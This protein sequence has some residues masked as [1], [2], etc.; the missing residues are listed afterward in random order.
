MEL[1][2]L[3][4][5]CYYLELRTLVGSSYYLMLVRLPCSCY[6]LELRT[7]ACS[8]YYLELAV[9]IWS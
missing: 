8:S 7:L 9:I 4:C 6:Y 2:T 3:D 5:S 1:V